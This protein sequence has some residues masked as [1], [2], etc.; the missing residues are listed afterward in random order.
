MAATDTP[1]SL[2]TADLAVTIGGPP[3]GPTVVLL[4]PLGTD[5]HIWDALVEL[6]PEYQLLRYDFPGHG[7]TPE[8][9]D[10][11][12][13][14]ALA[15]Q[16]AEILLARGIT[17]AHVVGMSLGGTTALQFAGSHP[18]LTSSVVLADCVPT[19]PPELKAVLRARGDAARRDGLTSVIPDLL[20]T[21]FSPAAIEGD[22][23]AV[24]YARHVLSATSAAGYALACE[25]LARVDL[26]GTARGVTVPTLVVCGVDDLPAMTAGA[27]WMSEAVTGSELAW[28]PGRHAAV[29][30]SVNDFSLLLHQFFTSNVAP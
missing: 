23:P 6:L 28:L 22:H 30:E 3:G 26:T 16:L 13:I 4:H 10:Q 8:A 1:S 5:H 12:D 21:W 17:S 2:E 11:F 20:D 9:A 15:G 14:E 24:Q 7:T 18:E 25:A 29:T 27:R 19:Y